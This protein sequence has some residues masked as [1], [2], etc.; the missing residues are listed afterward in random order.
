MTSTTSP[1]VVPFRIGIP[2]EVLVDL[3]ARLAKTR[4]SWQIPGTDWDAGT[5][6]DYLRELV[7]YW[8]QGYDWRVYEALL[9]RFSHYRADLDGTQI[10][11]IH[12]R[13]NGPNPLPII[14]THGYPDSFFRFVKIIPMLTDPERYGG[15][16]EDAFDVVVPDLPGYGFS[17]RSLKHGAI[18]GVHDL[19][20]RL[21]KDVLGYPRFV[22]RGGDWGRAVAAE[23]RRLRDDSV[24]QAG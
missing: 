21:M 4:W 24:E 18:F 10:H 17:G 7:R 11:F 6:I 1:E 13:G 12:E 20:A 19:W 8:Q 9:N 5:N 3:Q 16:A 22:A 2:D 14:L 23:G 15:R